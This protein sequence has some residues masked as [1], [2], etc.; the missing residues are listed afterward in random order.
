MDLSNSIAQMATSMS[1]ANLQQ[2][3]STAML[4]KSMD[5]ASQLAQ[6]QINMISQGAQAFPG[7]A[8]AIFD[9]RA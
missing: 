5:T 2:G 3:I 8:G 7:D 1:Q 4:K 9:A 6:G